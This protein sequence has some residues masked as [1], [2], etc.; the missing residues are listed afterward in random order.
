MINNKDFLFSAVLLIMLLSIVGFGYLAVIK[1][2]DLSRADV[3]L[4]FLTTNSA[5]L[6]G[7]AWGSSRGSKS[8]DAI[9]EQNE[10]KS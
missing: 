8:K 3:I 2:M 6:I 5:L 10:T 9:I 4:T 7:Y 1:N